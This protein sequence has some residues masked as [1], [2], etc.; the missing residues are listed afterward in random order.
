[1]SIITQNSPTTF[2]RTQSYIVNGQPNPLSNISRRKYFSNY[3]KIFN[4]KQNI[5]KQSKEK[6]N[7]NKNYINEIKNLKN[8]IASSSNK[9]SKNNIKKQNQIIKYDEEEKKISSNNHLKFYKTSK[10]SLA[11][12]MKIKEKEKEKEKTKDKKC[13]TSFEYPIKENGCIEKAN[14]RNKNSKDIPKEKNENFNKTVNENQKNCFMYK[15]NRFNNRN[16][17][18]IKKNFCLTN[19]NNNN[20]C[21][22]DISNLMNKIYQKKK[23]EKKEKSNFNDFDKNDNNKIYS[24]NSEK[25][26]RNKN[27]INYIQKEDNNFINKILSN[28]EDDYLNINLSKNNNILL[29]KLNN[30]NRRANLAKRN[31]YIVENT[32]KEKLK[33]MKQ[34]INKKPLFSINNENNNDNYKISKINKLEKKS[35][36]NDIFQNNIKLNTPINNYN[37]ISNNNYT[38]LLTDYNINKKKDLLKSNNKSSKSLSNVIYAMR[39]ERKTNQFIKDFHLN[40]NINNNSNIITNFSFNKGKMEL[41]DGFYSPLK[42]KIDKI[43]LTKQMEI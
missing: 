1:M 18:N 5:L 11:Y 4:R 8:N 30:Y 41:N 37:Y 19:E 35:N 12:N 9:F 16:K 7:N 17:K 34:Y 43:K 15:S 28:N 21:N 31:N 23:L 6:T 13:Q 38:P 3:I 26:K 2:L 33:L 42:N 24:F 29:N 36:L 39:E 40:N 14:N 22:G 20:N 27:L 25:I 10:Y 32:T